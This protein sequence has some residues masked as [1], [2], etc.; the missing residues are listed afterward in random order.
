MGEAELK[1]ILGE[2][3]SLSDEEAVWLLAADRERECSMTTRL[4]SAQQEAIRAK[5][6]HPTGKFIDFHKEEIEQSIPQRFE[7]IARTYPDRVAVKSQHAWLTY[8]ELNRAANRLARAILATRDENQEPVA[9]CVN[10]G[11][12]LITAHLAILKAG[13]FSFALDPAAP[14]SR[15]MHLLEDSRTTLVIASGETDMLT[16]P[17]A[18]GPK[19][20]VNLDT[21]EAWADENLGLKISPSAYSHIRYTSGSTGRAKG[22]LKTHRHTLHAVMSTTQAFHISAEDRSILLTPDALL[23]KYALEAILNGAALYFHYVALEGFSGLAAWIASEDITLYYSFPAAFRHFVAAC[24]PQIEFPKLRLIRLEGEPVYQSDVDLYKTRFPANCLLANSLSSTETGPIAL[25]FLDKETAIPGTRVPAG[26]PVDGMTIKLLGEDGQE[27]PEDQAGEIAVESEFLSSGY[28][29][30]PDLTKERFLPQPTEEQ[31][32]YLTGDIGRWAE[33]GSLEILGRKDS[34]VKIRSFRVDLGEVEAVLRTHPGVKDVAVAASNDPSG[35]LSL[36]AYFTSRQPSPPS[37]N[38]LR[39]FLCGNLPDYM[40]P[41]RF[42]RLGEL[43]LL[44][45]GKIDRG[46]LPQASNSRPDLPY[47]P[48]RDDLEKM[49]AA[50]WSDIL[51]LDRVGIHDNFFDLGGHSLTAMR[52]VSRVTD[53]FNLKMPTQLLFQSPTVRAMAAVIAGHQGEAAVEQSG[54][55]SSGKW[56]F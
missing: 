28:W 50:I 26:Y 19:R 37:T 30:K 14:Q 1:R 31:Q 52:I 5:C 25:Y 29:Q 55:A 21:L 20:I 53:R 54:E 48:P 15:T 11:V 7:R 41:S 47:V 42:V 34:Q 56:T 51:G 8:S 44:P 35:D 43:P 32:I 40:V 46:A 3:E 38:D 16:R 24:S 18:T 2:L 36:I 12:R 13:K 39:K 33:D 17:W 45:T 4:Q 23:G 9:I 10:D 27:V 49:L 22:G 6:F